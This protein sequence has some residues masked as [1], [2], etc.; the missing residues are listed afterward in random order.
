MEEIS[1]KWP[2]ILISPGA[3]GAI[4]KEPAQVRI[5]Q[6]WLDFTVYSTVKLKYDICHLMTSFQEKSIDLTTYSKLS[7]IFNAKTYKVMSTFDQL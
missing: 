3:Y 1:R 4:L 6:N 2:H 5:L 7:R